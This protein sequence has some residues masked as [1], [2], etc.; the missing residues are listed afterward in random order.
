[1]LKFFELKVVTGSSQ[2]AFEICLADGRLVPPM[3]FLVSVAPYSAGISLANATFVAPHSAFVLAMLLLV[4]SCLCIIFFVF[5]SNYGL[6]APK[7]QPKTRLVHN[8]L[9]KHLSRI[10]SFTYPLVA[11]KSPTSKYPFFPP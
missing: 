8:Y 9:K 11:G 4:P 10:A 1:V 3:A 6:P 2:I 5:S 7:D